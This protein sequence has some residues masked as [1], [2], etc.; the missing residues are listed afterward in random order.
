MGRSLP[1]DEY[2]AKLKQI[3]LEWKSLSPAEKEAFEVEAQHQQ[4]Q[5]DDLAQ[6]PLQTAKDKKEAGDSMAGD[7]EVWR[8]AAKKISCRRLAINQNSLET[9][10]LWD[11]PA[12]FGDSLS[13]HSCSQVPFPCDV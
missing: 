11:L 9:F 6:R 10:G 13:V 4:G 2:K 7:G 3:S 5:I 8:N 1:K 12:Q